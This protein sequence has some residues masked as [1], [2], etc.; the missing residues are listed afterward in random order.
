MSKEEFDCHTHIDASNYLQTTFSHH[1]TKIAQ[2]GPP[3]MALVLACRGL[4]LTTIHVCTTRLPIVV[5]C[6]ANTACFALLRIAALCVRE[7]II[8]QNVVPAAH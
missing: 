1:A 2:L 3:T 5:P 8:Y 6:Q 4:V 7:A